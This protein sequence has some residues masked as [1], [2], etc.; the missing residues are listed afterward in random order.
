MNS[1][2]VNIAHMRNIISSE[3][4]ELAAVVPL[5]PNAFEFV[6]NEGLEWK[7]N[8]ARRRLFLLVTLGR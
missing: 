1:K 8:S 6:S 4:W 2:I 3:N 7:A 5:Q